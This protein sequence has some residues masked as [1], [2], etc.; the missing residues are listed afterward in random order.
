[1]LLAF[2][3]FITAIVYAS[4]GFGGGSTYNALL[5][6]GDTDYRIIPVIALTCN[7]LVVTGGVIHFGRAG[8]LDLRTMAPFVLLSVP[9][10]WLGGFL[11]VSE[12][13]FI[14][15]LGFALLAT[16]F[17]M[18]MKPG[19]PIPGQHRTAINPWL[20]GLPV[21]GAIGLLSGIVGI[22]GGVF[23]APVLYVLGW[24]HPR[25]IAAAA[26][27]FILVNSRCI[28]QCLPAAK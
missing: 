20:L 12:I 13:A 14:G 5:V 26:S 9:M 8:H 17:H 1:M 24:G 15:L 25:R 27:F 23:L 11:P 18:L 7:V 19:D 3:F 21:G 22:G 2:A 16:V 28:W 10:A 4:V 6:L